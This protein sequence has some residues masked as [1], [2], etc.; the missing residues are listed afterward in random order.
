[1]SWLIYSD[2][3]VV[4]LADSRKLQTPPN[5]KTKYKNFDTSLRRLPWSESSNNTEVQTLIT[6]TVTEWYEAKHRKSSDEEI[7]LINSIKPIR[8]H[9][10]SSTNF[11]NYG[12]TKNGIKKFKCKECNRTF[13]NL[14]NT[15]F[16]SHKIAISEW[17]EYLI[18]LFEFHSIKTS[19]RDNRNS[20][21]TGNYWLKK[22]FEVLK[23]CQKYV[24]L[25]NKV[26]IDE[27]YFPL[28]KS[29][30][31]LKDGKKLRGISRNKI[32]VA[33]GI[34]EDSLYIKVENTSKPSDK[35]TW[36]A[37]G[38]VIQKGSHLIHDEER[39]HGVLIRNLSLTSE[40]YSTKYTKGLSDKDN[41]LDPINNIHYLI[42]RFM[43][44]HG[45]F[46]RESL[47]DWMNLI[48]FILSK[49][50]DVYLKIEKFIKL[51]ISTSHRVKY[52]DVM[53]KKTDNK[54]N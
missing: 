8:C 34:D 46:E 47:Q 18:H 4:W 12:Y 11:I 32:C 7:E 52:R 3:A 51:A 14:T 39:S 43:R 35:S 27:L 5:M 2:L 29:K 23:N 48:W 53:S 15:I 31:V 20:S 19:S 22:V 36:N 28:I 10:C 50:N 13:T 6:T 30:T 42:K 25:K 9:H 21:S 41:P 26:Y 1:M 54:A 17:I 37:Y 45:G 38:D 24:V 16:D 49:P 33:T 40:V 44:E